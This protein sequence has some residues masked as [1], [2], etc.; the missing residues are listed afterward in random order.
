MNEKNKS[1]IN[2]YIFYIL[3]DL[4]NLTNIKRIN[5]N[6]ILYKYINAYGFKIVVCGFSY[7]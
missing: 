2:K 6:D 4:Q 5:F 3:E 7:D 1:E